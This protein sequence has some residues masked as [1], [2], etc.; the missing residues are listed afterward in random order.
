MLANI[1]TQAHMLARFAVDSNMLA[2][3]LDF[4]RHF[5]CFCSNFEQT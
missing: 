2:N 1:I 5:E 4:E 3:I